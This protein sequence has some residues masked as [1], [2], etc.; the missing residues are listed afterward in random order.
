MTTRWLNVVPLLDRNE[1]ELAEQLRWIKGNSLLDS[2]A[3]ICTLVPEGDPAFDK[4]AVL[5]RRFRK[6]KKLLAGSGIKCGILLQATMGHGWVPDSRTPFQKVVSSDGNEPYIF[7]PLGNDFLRYIR[8]QI[9]TLAAEEPDFFMLD[10][11]TRLITGRNGCFCPLHLAEMKRR[12]GTEFTRE[13]LAQALREDPATGVIY[14]TLL[15]DSIIR[16]A[17]VIREEL[18][19]VNPNLP[20]SFCCCFYDV[21]HATDIAKVL[22][23]PDQEL[24]IRLNN[25]RYLRDSLRDVPGW[26]RGTA[27]ELAIIPKDVVV[28]DEPDTCP[29]NR[30]STSATALHMHICMALLEGCRGGKLWITRTGSF[31]PASGAAYRDIIAANTAFYQALL[32]LAPHWE[33]VR[34]PISSSPK[35]ALP[36]KDTGLD[37]GSAVLGRF[38]I[39]YANT[40]DSRPV[41]MLSADADSLTDDELR[42]ILS[43]GAIL[44]GR[45]ALVLSRRGLSGLTGVRA[46]DWTGSVASLEVFP[47][48]MKIN[49]KIHA[50]KLTRLGEGAE[51]KSELRHRAAAL[52]PDTEYVAPGTVFFRNSLGGA[53]FTF[54]EQLPDH[55]GLDV[56]STYNEK[57]KRQIVEAIE[58]VSGKPLSHYPED[59]EVLF[60]EGRAADNSR[61]FAVLSTTID[62]LERIRLFIADRPQA[63]ERLNGRGTWEP[64]AHVVN[65]DGSVTLD[66]PAETFKVAVFR[67]I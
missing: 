33:G 26:L 10:D 23:A 59:A 54:A 27:E 52:S 48:G 41:T 8:G 36:P 24:V 50:V 31:E 19:R 22:A 5:A 2:A 6:M 61:I 34:V 62:P 29:Q 14:D 49:A 51:I 55:M 3:F 43:R 28:L 7:C 13:S 64:V 16:L 21:R 30:Y 20:C 35:I 46:E 63:F 39:P 37:W 11:D 45:A 32:A 4:A 44:D 25:G 47:D 18:D 56:F 9:A 17:T 42:A 53:V 58:L 65:D 15:K 67:G 12:T 1:E 60:R 38:G 40:R 66:S 57:R